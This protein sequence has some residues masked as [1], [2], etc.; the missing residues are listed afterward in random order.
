[1]HMNNKFIS[2]VLNEIDEMYID[3]AIKTQQ[4]SKKQMNKFI[5]PLVASIALIIIAGFIL[6]PNHG[7][8]EQPSE[9]IEAEVN[10]HTFSLVAYAAESSKETIKQTPEE[11]HKYIIS[12]NNGNVANRIYTLFSVSDMPEKM[13]NRI[14]L[15]EELVMCF[16]FN[17]RVEGEGIESITYESL[18]AEFAQKIDYIWEEDVSIFQDYPECLGVT[19]KEYFNESYGMEYENCGNTEIKH[20]VFVPKGK[21]YTVPYAEQGNSE[22]LYALKLVYNREKI[23]KANEYS[24]L[25][26][27]DNYQTINDALMDKVL[28]QKIKVIINYTDGCKDE[29]VIEII[30]S[31]GRYMEIKIREMLVNYNDF[32]DVTELLDSENGEFHIKLLEREGNSWKALYRNAQ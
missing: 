28:G 19:Q 13:R 10:K 3:E 6:F 21:S 14:D 31:N 15:A 30:H 9:K 16:G 22:N 11:F 5:I 1:M 4:R 32:D 12:S 24:R 23:D 20:W 25:N 8:Y 7:V 26:A 2:D 29:M 18:D 27:E 17:L